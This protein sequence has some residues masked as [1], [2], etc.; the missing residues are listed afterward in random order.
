MYQ[1]VRKP[2]VGA[3]HI[4]HEKSILMGM[5]NS[6]STKYRGMILKLIGWSSDLDV[7]IFKCE[8]CGGMWVLSLNEYGHRSLGERTCPVT[9]KPGPTD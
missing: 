8:H 2:G 6:F 7:Q 3:V 4:Y 5:L 9:G 1:I